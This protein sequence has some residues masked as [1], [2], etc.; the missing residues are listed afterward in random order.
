MTRERNEKNRYPPNLY[1]RG[2][3]WVVDF[4]CRGQRY[5]ANIGPVSRTRAKEKRDQLKGDTAAG[6]LELLVSRICG[7]WRKSRDTGFAGGRRVDLKHGLNEAGFP[8]HGLTA[9]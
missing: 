8:D 5:T 6:R 4:Y 7:S 9:S 2:N 3:S 1:K